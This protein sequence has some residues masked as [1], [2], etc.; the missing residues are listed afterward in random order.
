MENPVRM[1]PGPLSEWALV[2]MSNRLVVGLAFEFGSAHA[3]KSLR[4][5]L[6]PTI[7]SSS[8]DCEGDLAA[9]PLDW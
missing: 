2:R 6:N 3:Y 4:F 9:T 1:C 5:P 7:A 8:G